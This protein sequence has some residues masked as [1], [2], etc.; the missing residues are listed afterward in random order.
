LQDRA[1]L[2]SRLEAYRAKAVATGLAEHP[3]LVRAHAMATEE[4][5][6]RPTSM[7]IAVQLVTLYQSYLQITPTRPGPPA[8]PDSSTRPD[9]STSE[10]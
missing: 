8:D 6:R 3:D 1:E 10:S 2:V 4:L 7:L 9:S 5:Q